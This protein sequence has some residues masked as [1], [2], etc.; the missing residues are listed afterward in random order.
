VQFDDYSTEELLQILDHM[1]KAQSLR[2]A[3]GVR[4]KL[5][6]IIDAA[7]SA[8]DFG[9]GRYIR[10]LLEQARMRQATRLLAPGSGTPSTK[11]MTTLTAAD[12]TAASAV[13]SAKDTRKAIGFLT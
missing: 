8:P 12:F 6:P 11:Q 10:N 3:P 1:V 2:L 7:R 13:S 4:Q 5:R 9:N